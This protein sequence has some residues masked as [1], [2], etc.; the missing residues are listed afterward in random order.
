MELGGCLEPVTENQTQVV[1]LCNCFSEHF[2]LQKPFYV[3]HWTSEE[4]HVDSK[5]YSY[6][7]MHFHIQT[8]IGFQVILKSL[9]TLYEALQSVSLFY[10]IIFREFFI[11]FL[12]DVADIT[13]KIF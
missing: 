6:Q 3:L 1:P 7:H 2:S 10:E 12:S 5:F 11:Y 4:M 8:C 9:R 13:I